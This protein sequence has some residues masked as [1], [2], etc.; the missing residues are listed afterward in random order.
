MQGKPLIRKFL[1]LLWEWLTSPPI[2]T[3]MVNIQPCPDPLF[4][5]AP[6]W[7]AMHLASMKEE[8]RSR[9]KLTFYCYSYSYAKAFKARKLTQERG[10]DGDD[11]ICVLFWACI[12]RFSCTWWQGRVGRLQHA[13]DHPQWLD[14]WQ[15]IKICTKD[16]WSL[17]LEVDTV[18][19]LPSFFSTPNKG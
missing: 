19:N 17:T 9:P 5:P 2:S 18:L 13:F 1:F 12:S 4:I 15:L 3:S 11:S 8:H 7:G 6:F 14:G 10:L 16:H